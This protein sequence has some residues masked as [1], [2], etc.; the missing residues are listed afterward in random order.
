LAGFGG[1]VVVLLSSSSET[2]TSNTSMTGL[3]RHVS[4]LVIAISNTTRHGECMYRHPDLL[5]SPQQSRHRVWVEDCDIDRE[6]REG[7][8]RY[9]LTVEAHGQT[10][11]VAG[12]GRRRDVGGRCLQ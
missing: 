12:S 3:D 10:L 5:S 8:G 7:V 4:V 11:R 6:E 1:V 2:A 9:E